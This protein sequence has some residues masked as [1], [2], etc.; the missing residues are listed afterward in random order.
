MVLKRRIDAPG[1]QA[2]KRPPVKLVCIIRHGEAQH[3]V[4]DSFLSKRDTRLTARGRQQAI[5]LRKVFANLKTQV[6]LTSPILR[7]M[8]TVT[9]MAPAVPTVVVPNARERILCE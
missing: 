1:K 6:V 7:A 4:S 9:A 8:Q 5:A 3:N 2:A